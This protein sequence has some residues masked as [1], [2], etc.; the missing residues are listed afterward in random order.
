MAITVK[1][2]KVSTIPDGDD[3]SVVRPSDWN[4]DHQLTG[5]VP[6]ANGGT[7][8]A[9]LTGYVK[10][11]GTSTMTASS[12][13]PNTDITGLGTAST[14]DAGVANGVATLDSSGKVPV[15]Q[16]PA[17]G[18]LN[19]QG[20]WNATT[21]TPTLTSSVGTKGYYY[22]VSVAGTT[23][24]NGITDW[25][26]GDWA[27]YN[28]TAWQK[29]DNTDA[30][31]SVNGY[32]GTVV[33]TQS[34]ISGTVPTSRTITAGTGLTGGGDLSANRTLAIATTGVS[35]ATYGSA[36]VVPV[37]AIN[38]QGQIT[39][40]TNTT[41]AIANTQVSGL[42]TMST[43]NS[44]SV[45][46]TGGSLNGVAIGGTTAG[47]GTFDILTANV[48][49]LG[50]STATSYVASNGLSST[51][52]FSGTPPTDG[53]VVDYS[54]GYGRFSAF[55]GDGYQWYTGGIGA[56][57]IM[58]LSS[59]GALVTN[60]T[61]TANG[62]V[63]TGNTGTVT[64]VAATAGTGISVSGSPI[65]TSGTLTITNTAPDQTVVLTAG[66]GISTSGTYPNFTITNTSPSSGGT[67]TSVAALTLG[68]TGTDLS[69]SVANGTTTPVITL[70]VPTASATNRGA[71]SAADWTTFNSKAP[72]TTFT[73][74]YVPYGQGTT[75]LNQSSSF[76]YDGTTL[77]APKLAATASVSGSSTKGAISY[78]T[79]GYSDSNHL[80]TF[81]TAANAYAQVEIQ[82]TQA[83]TSA[84][85]DMVVG[86]DLTTSSTYYGDFGIN[87][88][89]FSG[90]GSLGLANAVYLTATTGDLAIGTTTSNAIH[91]VI[92][93]SATDAMSISTAGLV[94]IASTLRVGTGVT[95]G[96]AGGTF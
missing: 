72:G 92:N 8:A 22:V 29:I 68:T 78:G 28:G 52:T 26:V 13:I 53:I 60:G 76:T 16:I 91:F 74:N 73:T 34:D 15:S 50:T 44:N 6:V 33:L 43:Q 86:N 90:T 19:Y 45:T 5:T 36:S 39:S 12:T 2:T 58:D 4:A 87:S 14:K 41:I 17:L 1:H 46:I 89:L 18:D 80:A 21:N 47:D 85:A 95:G 96:I 30:V 82:N 24:L 69:S 32:T 64:S 7:G 63:L 88:S 38:T 70:N 56:T 54:T 40:A 83:G 37:I 20:T 65:T 55:A 71:L 59:S 62:V 35:A 57:K 42:G 48:S 3:T 51:S 67:V 75:T 11:N 31:T 93:G 66:T 25:Q 61:V 81:Q 10:G 27:V 23:N 79:L 9:T 49:R 77:T 94:T 84:S